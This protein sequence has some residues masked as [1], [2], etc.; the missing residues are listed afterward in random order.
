MHARLARKTGLGRNVESSVESPGMG[1]GF[2][3]RERAAA[4]RP[5]GFST[6]LAVEESTVRAL[7]AHEPRFASGCGRA[8]CL[9]VLVVDVDTDSGEQH[10][11]LDHLLVI[12]ADAE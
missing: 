12:D 2:L 3:D 6:Q 10:D 8:G 4:G 7:V 1:L 11:A 9:L 5:R